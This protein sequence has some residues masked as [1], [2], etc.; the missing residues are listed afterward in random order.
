MMPFVIRSLAVFVA[1]LLGLSTLHGCRSLPAGMSVATPP[2]ALE[3]AELLIDYTGVRRS[4]GE[5]QIQQ[6]IF[7]E[8]F[9]LVDQAQ[10]LI[11]LDMFLYNDFQGE[12]PELHRALS[13]ELTQRLLA[14][15]A[16]V[17]GLRIIV[18]TD[19]FNILYGG[20]A[21]PH[22]DAL[23]AASVDVV[24]TDLTALPDSNPSWS[25]L[26]R[27]CCQWFGNS[28]SG[29]WL[30]NPVGP[31]KVTLRTYLSLLN[32]K[33]NHRKTVVVDHGD[34][35]AAV[36]AS[37]NPHD[38]SSAHGNVALR[39]TGPA[40]LDLLETELAVVRFSAPDIP[41]DD[42]PAPLA[43]SVA[44]PQA[45]AASLRIVTEG[46]IGAALLTAVE[47]TRAGDRIYIDVF[48]FSHRPLLKALLDAADRGVALRVLLD[49]NKDAFG[50][51]KNGVPNRQLASALHRGGVPVRWCNTSG[52]Q[53]HAKLMLVLRQSGDAE[54]LLG[55]ANFTR[56]NLNDLNL[57]TNVQLRAP[58]A[59]PLIQEAEEMFQ[60][61]WHNTDEVIYSLEYAAYADESTLRYWLYRFMEGTGWSSF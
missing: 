3:G 36:V 58:L 16:A 39:F 10:Q 46:R 59:H 43:A 55:S 56:R 32:F 7:D 19:P 49:P 37:A 61:R 52:E 60:R 45:A 47:Q 38:G 17:P 21:A 31:G 54:L 8:I 12:P 53:C 57:E 35:W 15:K 6:H 50:R 25:A 18:I 44:A 42:L 26:W 51:Q 23:R 13:A 40:A 2:R 1:L 30:P 27:L 41:L 34:S 24:V 14:R 33:A 9:Q 11:V 4:D 28:D 22:L 29:G 48:Y 5:R 20:V